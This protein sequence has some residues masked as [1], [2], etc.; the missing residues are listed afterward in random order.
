MKKTPRPAAI[1]DRSQ[2]LAFQ[3]MQP[4]TMMKQQQLGGQPLGQMQGAMQQQQRRRNNGGEEGF[5]KHNNAQPQ[6]NIGAIN[7]GAMGNKTEQHLQ[8]LSQKNHR[9]AK[10]LSELRVRHR[11]E[12]KV[13]SRL[14][15]E[16]MNLAS[17]CREAISQVAALKKE[18]MIYQ[19]RQN[20]LTGEYAGLQREVTLLK[21]QMS[22]VEKW[23]EWHRESG[24]GVH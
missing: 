19:K 15:M 10:E 14:T 2:E 7:S 18:L 22:G 16:N 6:G 24:R 11:E 5:F 13:V 17:R 4:T 9:L 20:S 1:G 12:T 8:V 23:S 21:K 3:P